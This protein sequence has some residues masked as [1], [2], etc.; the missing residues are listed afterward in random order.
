VPL[1][2]DVSVMASW[3]F[4]DERNETGATILRGLRNNT[5]FVPGIWWFEL[6]NVIL[7]GERRGRSEPALGRHFLD[8]VHSLPI[9]IATLPDETTV[10]DLARRH[11]LSFYDACYVELAKRERIA[12]ATFDNVMAKA[13]TAEGVALIGA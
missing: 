4:A 8:L 12:L 6:R 7:N 5:A 10:L 2:I 13:A 9:E 11:R 1:V 3:H